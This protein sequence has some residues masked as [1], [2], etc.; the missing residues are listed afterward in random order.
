MV[1]GPRNEPS[2]S[3]PCLGTEEKPLC[4]CQVLLDCREECGQ[5]RSSHGNASPQSSAHGRGLELPSAGGGGARTLAG[6]TVLKL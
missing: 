1:S 4:F 6:S 5:E 2:T 3:L